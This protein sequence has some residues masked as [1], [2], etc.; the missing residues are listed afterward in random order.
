M[1]IV[2]AAN[3]DVHE[4]ELSTAWNI[5]TA[6]FSTSFDTS[7]EGSF[8]GMDI[9]NNGLSMYLTGNV[10]EVYQYTIGGFD[11][12]AQEASPK[13]VFFKPDGIKMYIVG[14]T[15]DEVNEYDLST[16]WDTSTASFLQ[17]FSVATQESNPQDFFFKPDGTKMYICG[18]T[19]DDVNEYDL[20]TAWDISSATFNQT[21][22]VSPQQPRPEGIFFRSDGAK[23]YTCG[24]VDDEV[25]E[26]DLSTAWDIS[27]ASF[28]QNFSVSSQASTPVGVFFKDDGTKMY[29]VDGSQD[30][31]NEYDLTT[32]WDISSASFIQNLF[33]QGAGAQGLFFKPDGTQ[34]FV[35]DSGSDAV[36]TYSLGVQE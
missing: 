8:R 25:N 36:F 20:S 7:S 9:G 3:S 18:S 21:F 5:G 34:M 10:T 22:D 29:V 13:G 4:Y 24:V 12:S 19:G 15:D 26:Y 2:E 31:V 33:L 23:M 6:S 32:A 35:P 27:S 1:Y 28:V 17:N 11:V 14:T 16:E 30:K